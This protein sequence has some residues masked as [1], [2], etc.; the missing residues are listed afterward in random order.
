MLKQAMR[1]ALIEAANQ[2]GKQP[3]V[4]LVGYEVNDELRRMAEELK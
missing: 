1:E 3:E 2:F 4:D